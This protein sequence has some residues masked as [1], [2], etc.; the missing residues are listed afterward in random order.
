MTISASSAVARAALLAC[1]T[2]AAGSA[3][4]GQNGPTSLLPGASGSP[5]GANSQLPAPPL[6]VAP[7]PSVPSVPSSP[8]AT[9]SVQELSAPDP[10]SVGLLDPAHGGFPAELWA[11]SS[12]AVVRKAVTLLPAPQPWHSLYQLQRRLLLTGA[13]LPP[14]QP[15]DEPLIKL[16]ADRLWAMGDLDDLSALMKVVPT[17]ASTPALKRLEAE[18]DLLTGDTGGAC[19]QAAGLRTTAGDDP[20]AAKLQ[21]FCL[22]ATGKG[23]EAGLGVDLLRDQKVSDPAF[24]A[25]ADTLAGI[26]AGHVDGR[27]PPSPL[28]FAMLRL[29]KLPLPD[30]AADPAAVRA[31]AGLPGDGQ[32]ALAERAEA[33]GVLSID[34]LRDIYQQASF[35]P[36]DLAAPLAT[37]ANEKGPRGRALMFRAAVAQQTPAGKA[38]II[39]K[40]LSLAAEQRNGFAA[41]AR[42]YAGEIAGL[43]PTVD[44][45]WFAYPA[46]RALLA[47]Q[48][49]EPARLW[50]SLARAQGL[51]DEGAASAAAALAPLARLALRDEQPLA[52]ELAAWRKARTALPGDAGARR[53]QV[54][55]GLLAALGDKI[56]PEEWL[57]LL[58]GP[59][60]VTATLPRAALR[61]LL[62]AAGDGG[63]VGETVAFALACLGD[64][65][66]T[67]PVLLAQAVAALRQA[68]LEAEARAVA[69]EAAI[70]NGV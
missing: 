55:L 3:A 23:R 24:F 37:L 18:T 59:A 41:A 2:I 19:D 21:V 15:G 69:V 54:L 48:K 28:V 46:A 5:P 49:T 14:G 17:P 13:P 27:A 63:R 47:A 38:E 32:L 65:D 16:R 22:F 66:K 45:G 57:A 70:A 12:A 39:A 9:V 61:Q 7:V 20:F 56:P 1:L 67:E 50:L 43:V 30:P 4:W 42:L 26:G 8:G 6:A 31:L 33:L 29:A 64:L 60:S 36:G 35:A 10:G 25:A 34:G 58:D 44:L 53:D 68:G 52:P 11:N 40:A 62:R 51:A